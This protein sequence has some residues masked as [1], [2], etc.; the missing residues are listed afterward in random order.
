MVKLYLSMLLLL[1]SISISL[2]QNGR[3]HVRFTVK[4]VDCSTGKAVIILQVRASRADSTF[5]MGDANY[6]FNYDPRVIKNPQIISQDNFANV[7]PASDPNY[8]AQNLNGSTAGPTRGLVSL[9]TTYAGTGTGAKRVGPDW[10]DVAHIGFD[11]VNTTIIQNNCFGL[12]WNTDQDFPIT[13]MNEIILETAGKYTTQNVVSGKVFGNLQTCVPD[14]CQIKAIDD[15]F[16]GQA[17]TAITGNVLTND[18]GS[19][20]TLT[21]QPI[22]G[23]R[24]G[25]ITFNANGTFTY[26]PNANFSGRDSVQYRACKQATP[27]LCDNA[28][29][30]LTVQGPANQTGNLSLTQTVSKSQ[31][32]L[33]ETISYRIVVKNIGNIPATGVAVLDSL[34]LGV[35]YQSSQA[36]KGSFSSPTA[37]WTI[38]TIAVGDS[39]VLTLTVKVTTEGTWFNKAEISRMNERDV[40]STPANNNF[41]EDDIAIA[42]ISIPVPICAG[43]AYEI[44]APSGY[45][46]IQWSRNGTPI[47][48]ATSRT[49]TVSSAGQ[50]TFT[51]NNSTCPT[52]GCCPVVFVEGNC[53]KPTICLPVVITKT[54]T[55]R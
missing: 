27:T 54:R 25:T 15:A 17:G 31:P 44:S 36:T 29:L 8:N 33:G 7:A 55:G 30:Y 38:G 24:N 32:G 11:I 35:Q 3:F 42:C 20:L 50:Y 28:W 18:T 52:Q 22:T 23:P 19:P 49:L 16:S 34:P 53:C 48:G 13:G 47:A 43:D 51:A 45:T 14:Y 5:L 21:V 46:G 10:M 2:A 40:N 12:V 37:T 6:R 39:A 1:A 4:S 9:N 41:A 26:T